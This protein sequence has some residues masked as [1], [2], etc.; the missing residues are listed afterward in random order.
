M[1]NSNVA[2]ALNPKQS[3]IYSSKESLNSISNNNSSSAL[4]SAAFVARTKSN[5]LNN[6]DAIEEKYAFAGVHHI[7]DNH[8]G[9]GKI[10]LC[11]SSFIF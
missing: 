3:S 6:S 4:N 11:F 1:F 5:S 8:K 9:A 10:T 7:F 2:T